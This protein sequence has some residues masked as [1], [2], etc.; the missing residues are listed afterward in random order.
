MSRESRVV[1]KTLT[2]VNIRE[3]L[4][5]IQENIAA[6]ESEKICALGVLINV[7]QKEIDKTPQEQDKTNILVAIRNTTDFGNGFGFCAANSALNYLADCIEQTCDIDFTRIYNM[8]GHAKHTFV[9]SL[10]A[11]PGNKYVVGRDSPLDDKQDAGFNMP[12]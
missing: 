10:W 7:T 9:S 4:A 11:N 12:F 5:F 1:V 8:F 3:T 6:T 2:A